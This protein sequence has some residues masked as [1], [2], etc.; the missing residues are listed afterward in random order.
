[1]LI[2]I[3]KKWNQSS[4]LFLA[5]STI[6]EYASVFTI[7]SVTNGSKAVAIKEGKQRDIIHS[8]TQVKLGNEEHAEQTLERG[9]DFVWT[10]VSD[11]GF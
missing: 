2:S 4:H 7:P 9:C 11:G 5:I 8:L 3:I 10:K 6:K 1:M